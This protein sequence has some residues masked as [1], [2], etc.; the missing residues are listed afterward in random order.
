MPDI[1]TDFCVERRDEVIA[2]VTEKYGKDR[3]AQIVTFGTMAARAAIRDA[4]RALGVPLPDVDRVAKLVPSGPGGLTIT[5]ALEQIPELKSLYATQPRDSQAARHRQIDRRPGAQRRH[6]RR[7]GRDLGGPLI[8]YTPLV[9]FGDGGINTQYD[10]DWIE[11]IGLLK[12]DFLGL[13]NLTV[14]ENARRRDPPHD[15]SGRS[16]STT[17]PIDDRRRTR[18]SAR[19]ETMGVFQLESD[20]MKRVCA[21]LQPSRFEDIIAL[22]ALYRPGPME[23]DSALHRRSSTGARKPQYLHPK[24]EPILAETYGIA[25]LSGTGDADRARPRRLFDG[26]GRR[27]AQG[28]GQEAEG[29][30]S[31]STSENFVDGALATRASTRV[32]GATSSISS[33]RSPD[34]ASTRRMPPHTAGSPIRPRI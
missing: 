15:R 30:D 20:G 27:A 16:T 1:D 33:S 25:D 13:R 12:M 31:R 4:G 26:R 18:C 9:R 14:M 6:P 29:E 11:R 8:D 23:L 32:G 17:I 3:V 22:V 24:L 7:R 10:M 2:Y 21:E 34:T 5:Q 19:G 28:H